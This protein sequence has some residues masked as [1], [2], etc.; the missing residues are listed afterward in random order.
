LQDC[1]QVLS[2]LLLLLLLLMLLLLLFGHQLVLCL[3]QPAVMQ[4]PLLVTLLPLLLL[5]CLQLHLHA[6]GN[7]RHQQLHH[8]AL[9]TELL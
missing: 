1:Q 3:Q 9:S 8:A 2:L 5:A 6:Q 4:R 7:C